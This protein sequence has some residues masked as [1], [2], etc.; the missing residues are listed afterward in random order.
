MKRC[1]IIVGDFKNFFD[2]LGHFYLKHQPCNLMETDRLSDDYYAIYKNITKYAMCRLEDRLAFM[3][4]ENDHR[5]M[6][7]ISDS[8]EIVYPPPSQSP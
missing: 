3:G 4:K 8:E 1:Y 2:L 6:V 5:N 7:F